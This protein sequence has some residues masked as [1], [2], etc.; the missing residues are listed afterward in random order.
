MITP[1]KSLPLFDGRLFLFEKKN[2]LR[3]V[4]DFQEQKN[5]LNP[6][7]RGFDEENR[8]DEKS[9]SIQK[10]FKNLGPFTNQSAI[11]GT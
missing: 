8:L 11:L 4:G 7:K 9:K 10:I 5:T 1:P 2:I 3:L 6:K